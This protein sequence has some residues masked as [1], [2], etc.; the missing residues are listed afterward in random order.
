MPS[1]ITT[2]VGTPGANMNSKNLNSLRT[3]QRVNQKQGLED[4]DRL[5][6]VDPGTVSV[7]KELSEISGISAPH[8]RYH[9]LKLIYPQDKMKD[10]A[11]W[12]PS[13]ED[14]GCL[15][16]CKLLNQDHRFLGFA[17]TVSKRQIDG[18]RTSTKEIQAIVS[19]RLSAYEARIGG[20]PVRVTEAATSGSPTLQAVDPSRLSSADAQE[21]AKTS[22]TRTA[23]WQRLRSYSDLRQAKRDPVHRPSGSASST[24]S[25]SSDGISDTAGGRGSETSSPLRQ[26]TSFGDLRRASMNSL[27]SRSRF[28]GQPS[29]ADPPPPVPKRN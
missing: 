24:N 19:G 10:P 7:L 15:Q 29:Q 23:G 18:T 8:V 5:R 13:K 1:T 3:Q 22:S 14:E 17:S 25:G 4:W 28:F 26:R 16:L 12:D 6:A 20:P 21:P 2:R 9:L 27:R 11:D